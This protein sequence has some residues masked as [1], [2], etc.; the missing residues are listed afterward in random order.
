MGGGRIPHLPPLL[1]ARHLRIR[2][3]AHQRPQPPRLQDADQGPGHLQADLR[4]GHQGS[5]PGEGS[6]RR[7]GSVL[8]G[9][10]RGQ[11]LPARQERAGEGQGARPVDR[12][13]RALRRH[14]QVHPVRRVHLVV[15][16]V[17]DRRPVLRPRGDRERAPLHLRLA[18]RRGRCAP[19]HPQRQG[20]RV[21]LPHDLQL[22]RGVPARHRGHQGHRGG[23][24]GDPAGPPLN[25]RSPSP[26]KRRRPPGAAP[27]PVPERAQ[28]DDGTASLG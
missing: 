22:H 11:A 13:A 7:H 19:G 2:R 3:H 24:A 9:V 6:R 12:G 20:G 14:H 23:Q 18:R 25:P 1:R 17:L 8:R 4:R 28:R 16:G 15:P 27:L 10:P 5:P 26:S 21:A